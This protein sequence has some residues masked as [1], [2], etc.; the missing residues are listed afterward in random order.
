MRI[1]LDTNVFVSGVF[2]GGPPHKILQAW[3]EGYVQLLLSPAIMDEY[4]AVLTELSSQFPG[5]E[6]EPLLHFLA[7][8]SEIVLPH[9]LAPVIRSDPSDDKFLECALSG[10]ATCIV[11]GDK[12]LLRLS[13]FEGICIMSPRDFLQ[14][15][16]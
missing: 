1:V 8:H 16:L 2:F 12:H 4:R 7:I 11:S 3:R 10:E 5:I 13:A 9:P 15:Y 6:I 14:R